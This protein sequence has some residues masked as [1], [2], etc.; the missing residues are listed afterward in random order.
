[1]GVVIE[2]FIK[3]PGGRTRNRGT[4]MRRARRSAGIDTE[5]G[6]VVRVRGHNDVIYNY[7]SDR[8]SS[9]T[10]GAFYT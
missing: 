8:N 3:Y 4:D 2:I 9:W 6:C 7:I 1:M 10:P 5:G